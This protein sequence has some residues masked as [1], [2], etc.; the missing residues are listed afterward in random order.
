M[1]HTVLTSFTT[2]TSALAFLLGTSFALPHTA[3][4]QTASGDVLIAADVFRSAKPDKP[5]VKGLS[6]HSAGRRIGLRTLRN[7]ANAS[8][9]AGP[10]QVRGGGNG[11]G[12]DHPRNV[13]VNDPTLDNIQSFPG[14]PPPFEESTQNETSVAVFGRHVLVGYRSTANAPVVNIGGNLFYTQLFYSAYSI[15]HDGG[16]TFTSGFVPPI[17]IPVTLGDPSVGAD[18]AG[19]FFYSSLG[20]AAG[21]DGFLHMAVQI[22]RSD[23][24]GNTFGPGVAVAIDDGADKDWLAIGPD[25]NIRSRDNLYVTWTRF[26]DPG[27]TGVNGDEL[28]LSRSTDGGAT[29]SSKSIFQPVNEGV[30]TNIVQWSNPV[31]DPSS[32]RLYVPF[33]H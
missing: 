11:N 31:V 21:A 3:A 2:A 24:N 9:V 5:T 27:L 25:P 33:S 10:P 17:N 19:H 20:V 7:L 22:N 18:R 6:V 1:K 16:R 8:G 15:S 29:W 12:G 23:D 30:N 4:A 14:F 28:W 32:G 13:L 26:K